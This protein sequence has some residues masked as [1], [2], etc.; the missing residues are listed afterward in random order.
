MPD[1]L[2]PFPLPPRPQAEPEN[3]VEPFRVIFEIG[4]DRFAIDVTTRFTVTELP[5]GAG[6]VI[7]IR[8]TQYRKRRP[9]RAVDREQV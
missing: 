4:E 8:K 5:T 9:Q 6:S 3:D 2:I 7:P 1:K